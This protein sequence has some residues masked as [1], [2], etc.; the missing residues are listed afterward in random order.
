MNYPAVLDSPLFFLLVLVIWFCVAY[1]L[2]C[3][4]NEIIDIPN[5]DAST[6]TKID[7]SEL[8]IPKNSF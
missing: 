1:Y 5:D 4:P 3:T 2:F 7:D 6:E 8:Y